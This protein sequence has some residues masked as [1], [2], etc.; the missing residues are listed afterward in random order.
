MSHD[1]LILSIFSQFRMTVDRL[2]KFLIVQLR[3]VHRWKDY[4]EINCRGVY[5]N[6]EFFF[7]WIKR[8]GRTGM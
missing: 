6:M 3:S 2:Y 7:I 8:Y 1:A 4:I 5:K